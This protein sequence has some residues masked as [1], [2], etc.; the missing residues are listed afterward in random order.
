MNSAHNTVRSVL[1]VA[2]LAGIVVMMRTGDRGPSLPP[3]AH[4]DAY[5]VRETANIQPP[6]LRYRIPFA[7]VITKFTNQ[8]EGDS[9]PAE[10]T[11]STTPAHLPNILDA[12]AVLISDVATGDD[13][14]AFGEIQ[15]WPVASLSKLM[16]ALIAFEEL[17]MRS[18]V[19]ITKNAVAS[20]GRAGGFSAGEA[21]SVRDLI[22]ALMVVSSN[23][24]A[25]SIA[26][27]YGYPKFTE[28][29]N[30]RARELHMVQTNFF[31]PTGLSILNQSSADDLKRLALFVYRDYPEI[32]LISQKPSVPLAEHAAG[33]MRTIKNINRYAGD[34][35]FLGGKTG[36]I[37][38]SRQNLISFF[39]RNGRAYLVIILGATDRYAVADNVLRWFAYEFPQET[40]TKR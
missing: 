23:D 34:P 19:V 25:I 30:A 7:S 29:M 22:N 3:I 9:A 20:E 1:F 8:E 11:A 18:K 5:S 24:A 39:A 10:E 28:K 33:K 26:E 40:L 16:T 6:T 14:Y 37:T 35:A 15:R 4:Q 27:F 13:I 38:E 2:A 12:Q 36:Y 32:F 21:Y 31:E 17:D